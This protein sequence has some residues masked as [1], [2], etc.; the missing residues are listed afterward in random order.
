[1]LGGPEVT[2]LLLSHTIAAAPVG[3]TQIAPIRAGFEP[4]TD[5]ALDAARR[6]TTT[7]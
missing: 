6:D 3:T 2:V 1:M 4:K 7:N 5:A